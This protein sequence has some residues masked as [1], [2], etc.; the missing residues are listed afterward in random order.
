MVTAF[1]SRRGTMT[2]LQNRNPSVQEDEG[3]IVGAEGNI[4]A[5]IADGFPA[6]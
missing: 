6:E 2:P 4:A 3:V 5:A 1:N